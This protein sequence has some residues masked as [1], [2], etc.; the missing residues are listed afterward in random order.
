MVRAKGANPDLASLYTRVRMT[1]T[2]SKRRVVV[3]DNAPLARAIGQRIRHR[4]EAAG[5]TQRQLAAGRYTSSYI[6]A[7]ESGRV[8]PS[9]AAMSHLAERLGCSINDLLGD[10]TDDLRTGLRLEADLRL[11][12]GDWQ[13]ALGSYAEL[14]EG[15]LDDHSQAEVAVAT[16]EALSRLQRPAEAIDRASEAVA[17]FTRLDRQADAVQARYWLAAA[18]YQAE[19]V[20]E[21][22][23]IYTGILE[24][25]HAGLALPSDFRG[26]VLVAIANV[27]VWSGELRRAA[28]YLEEARSLADQMD[29]RRRAT[30]LLSLALSYRDSGDLEAAVRIG[31]RS[32][33]LFEASEA[34]RESVI[35]T[36]SLALT[37]LRL[38]SV[39]KARRYAKQARVLAEQLK[40]DEFMPHIIDTEAQIALA[41]E[42][43]PRAIERAGEA[44]ERATNDGNQHAV[45]DGLITR[46]R[47]RTAADQRA[48]ATE[49]YRRAADLA[50]AAGSR[51]QR[52]AALTELGDLLASQGHHEE[53][54]ALYREVVQFN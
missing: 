21:A 39:E 1:A 8:K 52:R 15:S 25:L 40:A 38:G 51:R 37:Y 48:E 36:N 43:W 11:A 9:V 17:L 7:L 50:A 27:E 20:G 22:R 54:F 44:V 29:D 33:A 19:N 12:S 42:D 49:D 23:S 16:A 53:A 31:Q 14:R 35:L 46:A 18:H 32:L 10:R 6:S 2:R 5:L 13:R 34:R 41:S 3:V 24:Q 26:R 47:A 28:A 4:R 45:I 30:F